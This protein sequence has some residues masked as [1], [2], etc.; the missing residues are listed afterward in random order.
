MRTVLKH[1]VANTY[2]PLLVKYLSKTRL[3][4]YDDICLEIP[5]QVFHPGFFSSTQLLLRS[6]N[7]LSLH[8]KTLLELGAGSGLIAIQAAKKGALATATD[9]NPVAIEYLGINSVQNK[10]NLE[11]ILSDHFD[12][13]PVQP[14]DIIAINPPYYKKQ[15]Q[16]WIDHAWY[17]GEKG[18]YFSRLFSQLAGY[19]HRDTVILMVLCDGCDIPMI[20]AL[21]LSNA[22][23]LQLVHTKQS[24]LGKNFI[25]KIHRE[26]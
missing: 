19:M 5:P 21:A 15:P 11:I 16:T 10:V 24:M 4:H 12:G 23:H 26:V 25:Y 8:K 3:Y 2:K 1:I 17:C 14:F 7:R 22:F 20:E 6:I 13:I 18:E 9:I